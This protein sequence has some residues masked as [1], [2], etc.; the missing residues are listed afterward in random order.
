MYVLGGASTSS[1]DKHTSLDSAK[2]QHRTK[3]PLDGQRAAPK[4]NRKSNE[5]RQK[6]DETSTEYWQKIDENR[7]KS[8]FRRFGAVKTD[9]RT[10]RDASETAKLAMLAAKLALLDSTLD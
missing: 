3:N 8:D 7:R 1:E 9:P 5:N 6:N 2:H 10:L 4:S